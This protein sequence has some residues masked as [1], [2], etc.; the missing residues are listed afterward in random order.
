MCSSAT[1]TDTTVEVI[2]DFQRDGIYATLEEAGID[3]DDANRALNVAP[4]NAATVGDLDAASGFV[5]GLA[6]GLRLRGE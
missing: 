5:A 1:V 6:V 3:M 4:E 2:S